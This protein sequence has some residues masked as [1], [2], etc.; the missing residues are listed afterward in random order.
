MINNL[1][2]EV[3][4][5]K[6]LG[7]INKAV[8]DAVGDVIYGWQGSY[9]E[10]LCG[11]LCKFFVQTITCVKNKNFQEFMFQ[12]YI[13]W[14]H[15]FFNILLPLA[16]LAFFNRA[17]YRKLRQV[18]MIQR[19]MIA[20]FTLQVPERLSAVPQGSTDNLNP[21]N[22]SEYYWSLNRG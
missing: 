12:F 4:Q 10:K 18:E 13:M 22:V 6:I 16:V 17:I 7:A 5:P 2:L 8:E 9:C 11:F 19:L 15:L 1:A 20:T 21:N 3:S 14:L